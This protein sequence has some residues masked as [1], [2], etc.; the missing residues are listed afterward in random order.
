MVRYGSHVRVATGRDQ[1]GHRSPRSASA[2]L[3]NFQTLLKA[4]TNVG[5]DIKD[6]DGLWGVA[7]FTMQ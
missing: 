7:P 6:A 4:L 2:A 1:R 5:G 3:K